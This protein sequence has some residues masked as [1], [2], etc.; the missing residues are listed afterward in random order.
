MC[1]VIV[2]VDVNIIIADEFSR[3]KSINFLAITEIAILKSIDNL[4]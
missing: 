1:L 3:Q 2:I 4:G